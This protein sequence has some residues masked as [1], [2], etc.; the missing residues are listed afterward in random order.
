MA[1]SWNNNQHLHKTIPQQHLQ[2]IV[3][4]FKLFIEKKRV[5]LTFFMVCSDGDVSVVNIGFNK[6]AIT[7]VEIRFRLWGEIEQMFKWKLVAASTTVTMIME[8][9]LIIALKTCPDL[10]IFSFFSLFFFSPGFFF[11]PT[12]T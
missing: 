6:T 3:L 7:I 4:F 5:W 1:H 11:Q 9:H 12:F 8:N 2:W 10:F